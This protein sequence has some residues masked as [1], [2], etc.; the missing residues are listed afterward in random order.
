MLYGNLTLS[1]TTIFL[2]TQVNRGIHSHEIL[3]YYSNVV[4]GLLVRPPWNNGSLILQGRDGWILHKPN[5]SLVLPLPPVACF[6]SFFIFFHHFTPS[7]LCVS[8][9]FLF[10]GLSETPSSMSA[11]RPD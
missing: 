3:H 5:S 6:T 9:N 2:G 10:P 4:R 7:T 1:H 11:I 8:C